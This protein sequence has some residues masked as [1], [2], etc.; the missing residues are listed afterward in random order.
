M[1]GSMITHSGCSLRAA[2]RAPRS[3]T[4]DTRTGLTVPVVVQNHTIHCMVGRQV[5][6][7]TRFACFHCEQRVAR[8]FCGFTWRVAYDAAAALIARCARA[9]CA[10]SR[11]LD[12]DFD[13]GHLD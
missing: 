4:A 12:G 3:L 11:L 10:I 13:G 8:G 9:P 2:C 7:T 6:V 5:L 1:G